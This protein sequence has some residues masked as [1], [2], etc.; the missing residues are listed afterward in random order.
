MLMPHRN[1]I[2]AVGFCW[3]ARYALIMAQ[4]PSKVDVVI[5]N[6]PSFVSKDDLKEI[7]D[8][9]VAFFKGDKDVRPTPLPI[10]MIPKFPE[11]T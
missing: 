10:P 11:S 6:H 7:K 3:G 8:V 2:I 5:A 9:P 4:S 1:K